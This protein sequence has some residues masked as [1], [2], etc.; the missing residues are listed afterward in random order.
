MG[1]FSKAHYS[2]TYTMQNHLV[3]GITV[4]GFIYFETKINKACYWSK[5]QNFGTNICKNL[6][7]TSADIE[8]SRLLASSRFTA[9]EPTDK[10]FT[11]VQIK[12]RTILVSCST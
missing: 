1:T 2:K 6:Y 9:R 10:Y 4:P 3:Q 12:C 8:I 5:I 7:R 11:L